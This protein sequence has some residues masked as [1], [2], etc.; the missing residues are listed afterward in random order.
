MATQPP[1]VRVK[2]L[3]KELGKA[4]S[5]REAMKS[6]GYS[7]EYADNPHQVM[8]TR[9]YQQV[10]VPYLER[11]ATERDRIIQQMK[12]TSIDDLGYSELAQNAERIARIEQIASGN[13]TGGNTNVQINIVTPS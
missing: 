1:T 8:A 6:A 5:M 2:R 3:A 13:S 10:V 7:Q 11:L 4:R 9:G 12:L